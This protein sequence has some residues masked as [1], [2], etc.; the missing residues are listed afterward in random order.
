[1][2]TRNIPVLSLL[3]I[4]FF[5]TDVSAQIEEIGLNINPALPGSKVKHQRSNQIRSCKVFLPLG[6]SATFCPDQDM[7]G[8]NVA[9]INFRL[10]GTNQQ[11]S[12][13]TVDTCVTYQHI[14]NRTTDIVCLEICDSNGICNEYEI[15]FISGPTISL[16]FF[17]DFSGSGP[18]P[19]SSKWLDRDIF[20]N[21]TLAER[22]LSVGFAT[23]DGLNENGTPYEGGDGFSDDL[24]SCFFNL[25]GESEFYLSFYIQPRGVGIKPRIKDS[26][27][28]DFRNP[29]GNWVRVWQ[30]NGLPDSYPQNNP[31][32]D[33]AFHRIAIPD[34]LLHEFF[35][36]R[37]RNKSQNKGLQ[38]LWHVDYVRLGEDELTKDQFRDVAFTYL[39][40]SILQ[41]YSSMPANQ[42][43][44]GEVRRNIESHVNNLDQVDLTMND[45]TMTITYEGQTLLR[46]TFIEP[47]DLWR[48]SPGAISFDFDMND[49]G[50]NN[51]E[52]LQTAL[53]DIL[54]AG[55]EYLFSNR[56]EFTRADEVLGANAN[57]QVQRQTHFSNYYAYDDGTAESAIISRGEPGVSPTTIAVEFHNNVAD[58]LQGVQL[59]IP[60]IEG[61]SSSQ[62][63]NLYVWLDSLDDEPEWSQ[64]G[65]RVYY[66]D[67]YYD[68]LQGFTTYA[69]LDSN[70]QKVSIPLPEGKFYVGWEQPDLSGSKI[71]VGYDLNSPIGA[72]YLFYNSGRG[73]SSALNSSIRKGTPMIRPVL[74]AEPVIP[75]S[76]LAYEAWDDLVI[77][78][79]PGSDFIYLKTDWEGKTGQIGLYDLSGRKVMASP[80]Q[81]SL[82]VGSIPTGTYLIKV[83]N[84]TDYKLATKLIEILK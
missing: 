44:I 81:G 45:P 1:M 7:L 5:Y 35:Q 63:F 52:K 53:F 76:V 50:S 28:V 10:C 37:I 47:V 59:H 33:F 6:G 34:S 9:E 31:A 71:P 66:A 48:L 29:E 26:L 64:T 3:L 18:Y 77:Y 40:T 75:T 58:N 30:M 8:I 24:T 15:A 23:F 61:N 57:N 19:D 80:L 68:T 54:Q 39:P 27:V 62:F 79:N 43:R 16:P 74:G 36:F 72:N 41:P 22:P 4:T 65:V 17:D 32:P 38:E 49:Q 20:V 82:D 42:F 14:G 67:S 84:F 13:E 78:P 73:W 83:V 51:Y 55:E 11:G 21:T 70:D 2:K 56:L 46:R 60:H 69:F 12:I 25:G